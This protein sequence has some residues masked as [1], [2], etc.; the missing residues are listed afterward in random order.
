VKNRYPF[1]DEAALEVQIV[2]IKIIVWAYK[3]QE[4][5]Q[6]KKIKREE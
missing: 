4:P 1:G 2:N 6:D 5:V 3:T